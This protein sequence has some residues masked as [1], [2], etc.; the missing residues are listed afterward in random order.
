MC[1]FVGIGIL[2]GCASEKKESTSD[3]LQV[4][5]SYSIIADM[6]EQVGKDKVDVKSIVTRGT[7][8]HSYEPT[9][10]NTLAVEK[11]DI[12]FSNGLNLETGKGW[13][14][15]LLE[16]GRKTEVSYEVSKGVTPE[17][18][19]SAG[20]EGQEDPHAWLSLKNGMIYVNNITK[21]LSKLDPDNQTYYESNRDVY[22]KKLTELD[23]KAHDKIKA[24]PEE[25][26]VLV[27]SEGAF[28]YFSKEYGLKA[29]YIWEI[30]TDTQGTPDQ[31]SRIAK[32]VKDNKVPAL[33]VETSV[34]PKTMEAVSREAGVGIFATIFT[35]SLG[36]SGETGDN[37]YDMM[38]FNIE[39]ITE[40]LSQ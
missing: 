33:F 7:D 24:I 21:E 40:G 32:I 34:S 30:N 39:K 20:D 5:A 22:I 11:A 25:T 37:Y 12:V 9:P 8:P 14:K 27:T 38:A 36:K 31:I 3:K 26:R 13:F 18:L 19:T 1:L 6:V 2:S 29:E 28:K 16:N 15:K 10:E 35:D 4:V 23:E 17:F